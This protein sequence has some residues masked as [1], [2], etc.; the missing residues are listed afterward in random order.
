MR[1]KV[2]I[3]HFQFL[4]YF[5]ISRIKFILGHDEDKRMVEKTSYVC[6]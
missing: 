6:L 5:P 4:G 1:P 2:I 3:I